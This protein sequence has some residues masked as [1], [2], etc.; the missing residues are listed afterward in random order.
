MDASA[1]QGKAISVQSTLTE[2]NQGIV[3][4]VLRPLVLFRNGVDELYQFVVSTVIAELRGRADHFSAMEQALACALG[5]TFGIATYYFEDLLGVVVGLFCVLWGLDRLAQ[6]R[7]GAWR[8]ERVLTKITSD[9]LTWQ[10]RFGSELLGSEQLR[11]GSLCEVRVRAELL[12][13]DAFGATRRSVWRVE[14]LA[15]AGDVAVPVFESPRIDASLK[16]AVQ[17]G[18]RL[19]LPVRLADS[20]GHGELAEE[21]RR[22]EHG[23]LGT[24]AVERGSETLMLENRPGVLGALR[25]TFA[26]NGVLLFVLVIADVLSAF[27][28]LVLVMA[29]VRGVEPIVMNLNLGGVIDLFLPDLDVLTGA[30]LTFA[31]IMLGAGFVRA[32]RGQRLHLGREGVRY[33]RGGKAQKTL[34]GVKDYEVLKLLEPTPAVVFADASGASICIDDLPEEAVAEVFELC[35]SWLQARRHVT[36]RTE[37]PQATGRTRRT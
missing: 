25:D 14:M 9:S 5:V 19:R 4:Q 17:L 6:L 16:R 15:E 26:R 11:R 22:M 37:G 28:H 30:E 8:G 36:P 13:A 32:F 18:T 34:K 7:L 3:Y 21:R 27:G 31:V 29:G 10:H 33:A 23:L 2:P 12:V 35:D 20:R 1:D 24:W